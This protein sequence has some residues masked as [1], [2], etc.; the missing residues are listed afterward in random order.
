MNHN[1]GKTHAIEYCSPREAR[2]Y[3]QGDC[4]TGKA[5]EL[6]NCFSVLRAY[7]HLYEP[8]RNAATLYILNSR[9]R[10][11]AVK[12]AFGYWKM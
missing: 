3:A 7:F 8:N 4:F 12:V 11:L 10:L 1:S 5:P 2:S 9:L 6:A